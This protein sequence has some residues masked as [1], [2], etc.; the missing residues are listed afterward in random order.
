MT[1][2]FV[3]ARRPERAALDEL[4]VVVGEAE[5]R[6]RDRGA[7]D[8]HRAPFVVRSGSGR[9]PR[10]RGTGSGRPS[11]ACPPSGGGPRDPSSRMCW[12]NSRARRNSMNLGLRKMQISSAA[13]PPKRM[14]PIQRRSGPA[15]GAARAGVRP[16]P[17]VAASAETTARG[18]RRASPSRAPC[19]RRDAAPRAARGGLRRRPRRAA[20]AVERARRSRAAER[21]H[22]D[23]QLDARAR[24][25]SAPISRCSAAPSGPSSSMSPSTATRRPAAL[26]ASSSSAARIDIGLAL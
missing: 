11:S 15:P 22:R 13:V 3:R 24:R 17:R 20:L 12:P 16:C 18:R 4:R 1:T 6:A 2:S 21:P 10:P 23:E 7:E 14:R 25:R 9:R 5:Q 26:A 8:A 19:R